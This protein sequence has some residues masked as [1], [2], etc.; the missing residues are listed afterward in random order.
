MGPCMVVCATSMGMHHRGMHSKCGDALYKYLTLIPRMLAATIPA[1][2]SHHGADSAHSNPSAMIGSGSVIIGNATDTPCGPGT[3]IVSPVGTNNEPCDVSPLAMLATVVMGLAGSAAASLAAEAAGAAS[4]MACSGAASGSLGGGARDGSAATAVSAGEDAATAAMGAGASATAAA[5]GS[6]A[7]AGAGSGAAA[8]AGG[9]GAGADS[10][11]VAGGGGGGGAGAGAGSGAGA[12]AGAGV[13]ATGTAFTSTGAG[14]GASAATAAAFGAGSAA[15]AATGAGGGGAG[16]A[17]GFGGGG[18]GGAGMGAF[19]LISQTSSISAKGLELGAAAA[20]LGGGG[21]GAG[22]AGLGAAGAAAGSAAGADTAALGGA[23]GLSSSGPQI[24]SIIDL[25]PD[26]AAGLGATLGGGGWGWGTKMSSPRFILHMRSATEGFSPGA[27]VE[28]A[29]WTGGAASTALGLNVAGLGALAGMK[30][31]GG[32]STTAWASCIGWPCV[33]E[34][35]MAL[36]SDGAVT[37]CTSLIISAR[38]S[39]L[40]LR[41]CLGVSKYSNGTR[42][43]QC[44]VSVSQESA[45]RRGC[46]CGV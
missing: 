1:S 45:R 46:G 42:R 44:L 40:R 37:P 3:S 31:A 14:F 22:A 35:A 39:T 6:G 18:G 7:G 20:G 34:Q 32:G 36:S 28:T 41:Q 11:T 27:V 13:S 23:K 12:G 38:C 5:T 30:T 2:C 15:G 24:R 26:D 43:C 25:G 16:A 33:Q 9:S 4:E 19:A 17:T 8:G 21:G 29:A 10:A